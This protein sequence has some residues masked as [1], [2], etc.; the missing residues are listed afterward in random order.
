MWIDVRVRFGRQRTLCHVEV[1]LCN[2]LFGSQ[3]L[4]LFFY[5]V[6]S[7]FITS[8]K[9]M[10]VSVFLGSCYD[11]ISFSGSCSFHLFSPLLWSMSLHSDE[12]AKA[13]RHTKRRLTFSANSGEHTQCVCFTLALKDTE[14]IKLLPV[15]PER[16]FIPW[17][18]NTDM[19]WCFLKLRGLKDAGG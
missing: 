6:K 8:G 18:L 12:P 17:A 16:I 14:Q 3:D 13:L 4:L 19:T 5:T 11:S 7:L 10:S 9:S 1:S 15:R 2:L